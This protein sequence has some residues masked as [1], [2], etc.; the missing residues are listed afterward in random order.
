[1]KLIAYYADGKRG[2]RVIYDT[3]MMR[4]IEKLFLLFY[5]GRH[6]GYRWRLFH[7]TELLFCCNCDMLSKYFEGEI[8]LF[9]VD[10]SIKVNVFLGKRNK[11]LPFL[12]LDV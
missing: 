2:I 10:R 3:C 5:F 1:M 8:I 7:M 9:E 6:I 11:T 4:I 12:S